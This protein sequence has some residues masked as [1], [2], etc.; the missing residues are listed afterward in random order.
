MRQLQDEYA[1]GRGCG[2]KRV[3]HPSYRR[4]REFPVGVAAVVGDG[5]T[6]PIVHHGY[7]LFRNVFNIND[8]DEAWGTRVSPRLRPKWKVGPVAKN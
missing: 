7:E 1:V 6:A 2:R 8:L 3:N 5:H 4:P